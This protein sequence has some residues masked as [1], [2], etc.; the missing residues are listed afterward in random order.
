[1]PEFQAICHIVG[2]RRGTSTLITG[3]GFPSLPSFLP[4]DTDKTT[5]RTITSNTAAI[6]P[7]I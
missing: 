3:D 2:L 5:T 6:M 1:M 4:L 7:I